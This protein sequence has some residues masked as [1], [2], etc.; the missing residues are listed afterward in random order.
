MI[1]DSTIA[2]LIAQEGERYKM[3]KDSVGKPTT[4]VGHLIKPGEEYL[5]NTVLTEEDVHK[6]LWNDLLPCQHAIDSLVKVP[7][8]QNQFDALISFEF[9]EGVG[10]LAS[11]TLL[12][13]INAGIKGDEIVK[14]FCMWD[15]VVVGGVRSESFSILARRQ[16]EASLFNS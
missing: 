3:Y 10:A 7:L 11:S 5:Y 14:D 13:N 6:I 12:K 1:Q 4:G 8:T 9:N 16:R 2:F 15:K